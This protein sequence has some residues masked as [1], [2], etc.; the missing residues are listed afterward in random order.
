M[1]AVHTLLLMDSKV[2]GSQNEAGYVSKATH[3][4]IMRLT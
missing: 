3:E 2:V 4:L 1:N